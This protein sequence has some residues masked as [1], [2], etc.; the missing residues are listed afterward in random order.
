MEDK[1][2]NVESQPPTAD[3][4]YRLG[5]RLEVESK[6]LTGV[7]REHF[8]DQK[9][10]CSSCKWASIRRQHSR[11]AR[12]IFCVNFSQI[13]PEDIKECTAY[14]AFGSL[15]LGQMAEIATLIDDRKDR[16]Q[17]YL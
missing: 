3:D 16:N 11:N 8:I 4:R 12:L 9:S 13:M 14:T 15:S 1:P 2:V 6:R 5:E 10:L 17:G 7:A